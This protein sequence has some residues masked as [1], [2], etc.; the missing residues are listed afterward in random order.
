VKILASIASSIETLSRYHVSHATT[1]SFNVASSPG[2]QMD[3]AMKYGLPG[4]FAAIHAYG[5]AVDG[6]VSGL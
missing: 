6:G 5:V 2:D 1:W 3:V 4:T